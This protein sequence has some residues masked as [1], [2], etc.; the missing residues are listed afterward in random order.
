MTPS[1]GGGWVEHVRLKVD[2]IGCGPSVG[3]V[4]MVT[5]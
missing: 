1:G 5:E 4:V 2:P 3:L